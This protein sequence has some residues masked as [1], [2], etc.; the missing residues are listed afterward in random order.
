M[1]KRLGKTITNN[2]SLKILAVILAVVLWVVV[3]NIDDPTT[4]KTYTTNVVAENTDYI[5]SQN[6]Y[7]E[8]LDS[9]NVVS[10][11]VSAARSV[12]DE[13]SNADFS[14]TADMENIEY[15]EG[16]G[17]YR[18]PVTIT[19]KRYS[20]KVSV[21]SKQLYLEVALEDRG[22]CQKAI[23]A[24]TKGTV[25]D[26]CALGTVQIVGSNLL[27]VSGPASIVSQIDT[28]VATINVEGMSTDV[29]DSVVPVLYDADGNVIDTT[30]LTLSL[31]T[32]NIS[33]Q[34]LNTK[35]VPLEFEAKGEPADGYVLTGVESSLDN[36]RIKGEA[37]T[38]NTVS[39]IT[40]PQE[41]LD[42]S[43]ITEDLTTTVD[44][45]SYLPSQTALVLNSDAKVEVTS[46]K[47]YHSE[48]ARRL[49]CK[50]HGEHGR[51][52]DQR[53]GERACGN[54]CKRYYRNS[55]RIQPWSGR[56]S[57]ECGDHAGAGAL[58]GDWNSDTAGDN[59]RPQH[60]RNGY[61]G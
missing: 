8:P 4:S 37:A 33:A 29:T 48:C 58:L 3:I 31:S 13:L 41:V 35:D 10:F 15:D 11:R 49:Q 50:L 21:V 36:V 43:G 17:I 30:K 20:N 25:M 26:G 44:I 38:L 55:G 7:Y 51:G 40:I 53:S 54:L 61:F 47:L 27:K 56:A 24:A 39:K 42:I 46:G 9:S 6:K 57:P 59:Y 12:H 19:A 45:S 28:A 2:F 34:I 14:A 16:S 52:R 32:V 1:L 60:R 18:V 23:T 5:T 22:T